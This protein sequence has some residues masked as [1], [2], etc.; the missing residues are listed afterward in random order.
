M[1][2]DQI[3]Y[4]EK[5]KLLYKACIIFHDL[6]TLKMVYF[7]KVSNWFEIKYFQYQ[8]L[9]NP[10]QF[11]KICYQFV[12]DKI[13]HKG[14]WFNISKED[15]NVYFFKNQTFFLFICMFYAKSQSNPLIL[16]SRCNSEPTKY[17]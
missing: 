8:T 4:W 14:Q 3:E 11:F 5:G 7:S 15:S 12:I 6:F 13:K 16:I 10:M 1:H 17:F 2:N 9:I